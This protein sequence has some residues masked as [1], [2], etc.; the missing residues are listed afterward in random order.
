[1]NLN[2]VTDFWSWWSRQVIELVPPVDP[3]TMANRQSKIEILLSRDGARLFRNQRLKQPLSSKSAKAE[4]TDIETLA[5]K[6]RPREKVILT[7]DDSQCFVRDTRIPA[8][9][10]HRAGEILNLELSR[11]SPLR[12]QDVFSAWYP[13]GANEAGRLGLTHIVT[14]RGVI[15]S[16]IEVLLRQKIAVAAVAFRESDNAAAPVVLEANGLGFGSRRES[17]WKK[18]AASL[19]VLFAVSALTLTWQWSSRLADNLKIA[20]E[21]LKAVL[22]P[23]AANRKAIDDKQGLTLQ[24]TELQNLRQKSGSMLENW[25]ELSRGLP[26]TAWLQSF[27]QKGS[28]IVL[29]GSAADAENLIHILEESKMFQGVKF[30]SPVIK[31]PGEE[32]VRFSIS[33]QREGVSK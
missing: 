3:R 14:K 2:T 15:D 19:G 8:A 26:D 9:A 20:E 7:I 28:S 6:I 16:T 13:N 25:E 5:Q 10:A 21:S 23:A 29:E 31:N 22:A 11:V 30:V 17:I 4:A 12:K 27:S 33:M 1:M 18:S 24:L 32:K